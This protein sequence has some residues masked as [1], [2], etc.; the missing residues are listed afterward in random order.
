MTKTHFITGR[1]C[2]TF[3]DFEKAKEYADKWHDKTISI[4]IDGVYNSTI[5]KKN[6]KWGEFVK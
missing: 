5:H 3:T 6:G 4:Y 1:N 2:E